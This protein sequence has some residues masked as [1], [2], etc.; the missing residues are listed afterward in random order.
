MVEPIYISDTEQWKEYFN[1]LGIII[2]VEKVKEKLKDLRLL[3]KSIKRSVDLTE[4]E[5][6]KELLLNKQRKDSLT[7]LVLYTKDFI[8]S[9]C[10]EIT[11]FLK[12]NT[13]GYLKVYPRY[14][15][16]STYRFSNSKPS[17]MNLNS[18]VREVVVGEP[19]TRLVSIDFKHQEPWI[20]VNLLESNDLVD[21]L[22]NNEDFYIGLLNKFNIPYT[23]SNR[24]L[25]KE[26]W[27]AVFYGSGKYELIKKGIPWLEEVY[28]YINEHEKIISLRKK[29]EKN[30]KEDK[31]IYTVFG[32]NRKLSYDGKQSVRQGF[33]SI[34]Q[35]SGAGVMYAGLKSIQNAVYNRP[36]FLNHDLTNPEYHPSYELDPSSALVKVYIT[37]HDEFILMVDD[38]ISDEEIKSFIS[39]INFKIEGWTEPR[40]EIKIGKNWRDCK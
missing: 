25:M 37:L 7:N 20:I 39:E 1:N 26:T 29:V 40:L 28:D 27:N 38:R 16:G 6:E 34:F 5:K 15:V 22:K 13:K 10:L 24:Q 4:E 30:L 23:L 8:D 19:G 2:D 3:N 35:M 17:I 9:G 31:E 12:Q 18:Y 11:E 33:N 14:E 32:L 21:I 36:S